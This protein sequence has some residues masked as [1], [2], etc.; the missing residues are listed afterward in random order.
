MQLVAERRSTEVCP[1][2]MHGPA[3]S[4]ALVAN[5]QHLH[6]A[7]VLVAIVSPYRKDQ[8]KREKVD[9]VE[10][11]L[12]HQ[13]LGLCRIPRHRWRLRV[14][15]KVEHGA[16]VLGVAVDEDTAIPIP[17]DLVPPREKRLQVAPRLLH[18]CGPG[19]LEDRAPYIQVY[20]G[21]GGN[22]RV[23]DSLPLGLEEAVLLAE[24]FVLVGN[25]PS[26]VMAVLLHAGAL[27]CYPAPNVF[28][29]GLHL[30]QLGC[31]L[32]FPAAPVFANFVHLALLL[33]HELLPDREL[34]LLEGLPR[35]PQICALLLQLGLRLLQ[36]AHK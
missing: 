3:W 5:I 1:L 16:E 23:H 8:G 24:L 18:Q 19:G 6:G 35:A 30:A 33:R 22:L 10:A 27:L 36:P 29:V 15:Q 13:R 26:L 20:G 31:R 34:L 12:A 25:A 4:P 7:Q 11:S 14:A 21:L 17:A 32:L 28:H 2:C 9:A